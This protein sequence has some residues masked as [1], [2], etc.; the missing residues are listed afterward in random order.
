MG[1]WRDGFTGL[2]FAILKMAYFTQVSCK[3]REGKL[4]GM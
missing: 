1:G 4:K 3:I 2:S